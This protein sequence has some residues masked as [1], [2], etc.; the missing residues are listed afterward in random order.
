MLSKSTKTSRPSFLISL[1]AIAL[2]VFHFV[3]VQIVK[4]N[5]ETPS[6]S[7]TNKV[8]PLLKSSTH[9]ADQLVTVI[10]TL[11]G[12]QSGALNGFMRRAGVQQRQEM[13]EFG[14]FSL[15]LPFGMVAE[16]ASF[17][18]ISYVSSNEVVRSFGHVSATTGASWR[19][20]RHGAPRV[21]NS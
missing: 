19:R 21:T 12:S 15:S 10:V 17:P 7:K 4:A 14:I 16:L 8:S 2:I 9:R 20:S 5:L 1:S 18:E 3:S 6:E 11:N 13:K